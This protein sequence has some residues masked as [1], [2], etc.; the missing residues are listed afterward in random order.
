[1]KNFVWLSVFAMEELEIDDSNVENPI[2]DPSN[3]SGES[4]SI[5]FHF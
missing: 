3:R 5:I 4:N 2:P 1:M